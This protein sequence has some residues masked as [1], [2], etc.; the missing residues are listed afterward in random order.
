MKR[1]LTLSVCHVLALSGLFAQLPPNQPE[2]DCIGAIPLCQNVYFQANAYQGRGENPDEINGTLSCMILGERNSVWYI[3]R[4]QTPGDL[5]FTITPVDTTDD[6]DWAVYNLTGASCAQIG[7]NPNLEVACNFTYNT[8]CAGETG[9]NGRTDCAG[10]FTPCIPVLAGQTFVLNVSNFNASNAGYTIDFSQSNATLFDGLP[11]EIVKMTS[12]CTGVEVEFS[13]NVLC[14]TVDPTDFAFSGPD[15][16]YTISQ[17]MSENCDNGGTFDRVFRLVVDPPIQ[18]AGTYQL[19]LT[20]N[21]TDFCGN[22]ARSSVSNIYMPLPPTA[23]MAPLAAQCQE[24]NLFTFDYTGPSAVSA[25]AW[26]FGDGASSRLRQPQHRYSGYGDL[27]ATLVIRDVNGCED[28]ATQ[29]VVVHPA[30][31]AQIQAIN[32]LCEDAPFQFNSLSQFPDATLQT[33]TW[34]VGDGTVTNQPSFDHVL[35]EAGVYPVFLRVT[36]NFGCQDTTSM[37]LRVW[38]K[39]RVD[40]LTEENVCLGETATLEFTSTIPDIDGD[41]IVAWRWDL[42][43]SSTVQG[44]RFVTHRYATGGPKAVQLLAISDKGCSDSTVHVQ[45][46]WAPEPPAMTPDTVCLGETAFLVAVPDDGGVTSWYESVRDTMPFWEGAAYPTVPVLTTQTYFVEQLTSQGCL[47]DRAA[48][49]ATTFPLGQG[50]IG[51]SDTVIELPLALASV[52]LEGSVQGADFRWD[53]GDNS[54]LSGPEPTHQYGHPGM[55]SIVLEVEDIYGCPYQFSRVIEV[56]DPTR[57]LAPSAFSPNGDGIN[58]AWRVVSHLLQP[59]EVQIFNRQ[60]RMIFM[61]ND[62]AFEWRG[63]DPQ[64]SEASEGVYVYVLRG[65]DP[66]GNDRQLSGTITLIR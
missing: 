62:P 58:E 55:Y 50:F 7:V 17:V 34:N 12:F 19:N 51:V 15:G 6:Y 33:L 4:V 16:P 64:G 48:I 32:P 8:G 18:Q 10:Q 36:N 38:P 1:V 11:P 44:Q 2:Q 14:Q 24:S 31:R 43:D 49:L 59:F 37:R 57:L 63:H 13:E 9:P 54:F 25:Y 53:M 41:S 40:F 35:A 22:Q 66:M 3:F 23:A 30:P 29:V 21:I 42:G 65:K 46:I 26:S 47:S 61:S 52:W 60:G 20:G 45:M 28:T 27:T 39:P 56:K 5:C